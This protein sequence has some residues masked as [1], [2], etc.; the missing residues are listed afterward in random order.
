MTTFDP[1]RALVAGA[2]AGIAALMIVVLID[3]ISIHKGLADLR[4]YLKHQDE[5]RDW[6]AD[7]TASEGEQA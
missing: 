7:H 5:F 3:R 1:K 6:L 4:A 2:I